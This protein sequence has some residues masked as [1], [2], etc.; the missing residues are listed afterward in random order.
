MTAQHRL[1]AAIDD[2]AAVL[3]R[4]GVRCARTDAELLAAHLSGVGRGRLALGSPAEDFFERFG[5][6][7]AVR[8]QR[9]PLQHIT[10]TA[11]F[12]PIE[13]EVGPGVFIPRPET[14]SLLEWALTQTLPRAPV[15]VDLCTGSGALAIA[16][17]SRLPGAR[18]T[19]VDD[20]PTALEYA[21]RNAASGAVNVNSAV[22]VNVVAGDVRDPGLLTGMA[23]SVDLVVANPPYLPV[24][25]ELEP[26]V[27]QHDPAHALF[28]G[29]DGMEVITAVVACAARLLKPGGLLAVEHDETTAQ[30]TAELVARCLDGVESHRDLCGRPRFVTARRSGPA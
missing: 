19:A 3:A 30:A 29:P 2:A 15:I 20:D 18:V 4:A 24:D 8:A 14:E 23:E 25:T 9:V 13:V 1:W 17:A 11:A 16:L 10:G 5:R 12:G 28:G 21:R 27:A 7:V 22:N 6:A 26:E